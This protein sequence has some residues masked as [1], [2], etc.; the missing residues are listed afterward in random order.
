MTTTVQKG[1]RLPRD[2][3]ELLAQKPNATEYLIRA[4]R[5]KAQ[6][7]REEEIAASLTCLAF[8]SEANDVTDLSGAQAKVISVVD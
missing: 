7:E 8:D 3:V 2:V 4:V 1:F 5:E 6:R